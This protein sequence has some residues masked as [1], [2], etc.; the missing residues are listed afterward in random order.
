MLGELQKCKQQKKDQV[1]RFS[2]C[3]KEQ[4]IKV[5]QGIGK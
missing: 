5:S 3:G 1:Y 4:K 2:I